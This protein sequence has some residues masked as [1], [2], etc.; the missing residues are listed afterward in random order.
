MTLDRAFLL[1]LPFLEQ[2]L[3]Y[4]L[5]LNMKKGF[6]I[7]IVDAIILVISFYFL[8]YLKY[9]SL[10]IVS[11]IDRTTIY[12][13]V[14][15]LL[16]SAFTGK[17]NVKHIRSYRET[18]LT[19]AF[20]D[21]VILGLSVILIRISKPFVEFR[22]IILYSVFVATGLELIFSYFYVLIVK[23][24][25]SPFV[26]EKFYNGESKG[27]ITE[28]VPEQEISTTTQEEELLVEYESFID[29]NA[30]I[31][32]ETDQDTFNFI[33]NYFSRKKIDTLITSTT[34]VFN[35]YNQIR[36]KYEVVIN[37]KRIND[38]QYI[39]KFFEAVN[40]KLNGGGNIH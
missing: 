40:S 14:I 2:I 25:E 1:F 7:F 31:I 4:Y 8:I 17:Y 22:F 3:F 36:P 13:L 23:A 37:L 19:I 5:P 21:L 28:K 26:P 20:S 30:I 18:L 6:F 39:N 33:R 11:T 27:R 38:I 15:W 16:I 9:N 12:F 34:T 29:L 24:L 10:R 32:E 35:I